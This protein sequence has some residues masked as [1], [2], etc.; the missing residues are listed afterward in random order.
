MVKPRPGKL[1]P[2]SESR[3]QKYNRAALNQTRKRW[4]IFG[5]VSSSVIMLAKCWLTVGF[6]DVSTAQL[7]AGS[8]TRCKTGEKTLLRRAGGQQPFRP[9]MNYKS[10]LTPSIPPLLI[11]I[12]LWNSLFRSVNLRL[13]CSPS[14]IFSWLLFLSPYCFTALSP[15]S[16]TFLVHQFRTCSMW[17]SRINKLNLFKSENVFA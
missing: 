6:S 10:C 2:S 9:E 14:Q 12:V 16:P 17:L 5:W 15:F 8:K 7:R 11:P 3:P 13:T 4:S 1:N